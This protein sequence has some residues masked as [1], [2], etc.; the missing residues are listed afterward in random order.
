M[1]PDHQALLISLRQQR[2]PK[3]LIY[4]QLIELFSWRVLLVHVG[5]HSSSDPLHAIIADIQKQY[6]NQGAS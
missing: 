4:F 2:E 5:R 1:H 3:P 6:Q